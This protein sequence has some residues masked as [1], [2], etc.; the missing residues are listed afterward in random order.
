V[1]RWQRRWRRRTEIATLLATLLAAPGLA[2]EPEVPADVSLSLGDS[3]R[4]ELRGGVELPRRAP[5]LLRLSLVASRD[6][7]WGTHALVELLLRTSKV[8]QA[9]PGHTDVPLRVGNLSLRRGGDMRWSHSHRSGRDADLLLYLVDEVNETPV[10]PDGFVALDAQGRARLGRGKREQRVR[11]DAARMWNA[12]ATLLQDGHVQVQHL[13][14]AEPLRQQLL[15][16]ARVIGAPEWLVQRARQVISEPAHAGRHDDHLHVRLYCSRADRLAGCSDDGPRWPWIQGFDHEVR[17]RV[18]DLLAELGEPDLEQ[19]RSAL[20]SLTWMQH[21]DERATEALVW[22]A[23]HET[24]GLRAV[25]LGA[26]QKVPEPKA[27]QGLVRAAAEESEP[28]EV[29]TLLR[30]ALAVATPEQAPDVLAWLALDAG[31]LGERL[32]PATRSRLRAAVART[33]RPWLLEAA[34]APLV[35]LLD[36]P[37]PGARRSAL[38]SLECLANRH[39]ADED[40]AAHWFAREGGRGRLRW[41]IEG[42]MQRGLPVR[43]NA[44]VLAPRLIAILDGPDEA[45]AL[46]AQAWLHLLLGDG[47]VEPVETATLRHRAWARWWDLHGERYRL[48][49][50]DPVRAD[51]RP[52]LGP[53]TTLPGQVPAASSP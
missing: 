24:V 5:G 25:A 12:V 11:F 40:A 19:R 27:F 45:A 20:V 33:V 39:L 52:T 16:Q 49:E 34:A 37:D 36:D 15:A 10:L 6:T 21:A 4:G 41:M 35:A 42:F 48:D 22:A 18:D 1:K 29:E 2:Q 31:D 46:N 13:Y 28:L 43:G 32:A 38:R 8:L 51:A 50:A 47:P 30:A 23:V 9:M 3:V 14:L 44:Q 17:R 53:V 26:L 7:G